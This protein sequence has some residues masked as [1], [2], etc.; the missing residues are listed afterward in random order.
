MCIAIIKPRGIEIPDRELLRKCWEIN[1]DGGGFM[2][3][4]G[5]KVTIHKGFMKFKKFYKFFK[6][7]SDLNDFK[8]KD[9]VIHFR[10]S[11]SGGINREC[12]HPFPVSNNLEELRY[13]NCTCPVGFAHNGIISG[14]G[15]KE[16][17]DTM[18]YIINVV[19]NIRD[20]ENSEALIDALAT[21]NSSRFVALTKDK[22]LKGG[23]WIEDNGL[24][25]SNS[26]YK[27]N[28]L[29]KTYVS[30]YDAWDD[31]DELHNTNSKLY[32]G[33]CACCGIALPWEELH[34]DTG[35][36]SYVCEDCKKE[37]DELDREYEEEQFK[38]YT[39]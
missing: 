6:H 5:T 38:L 15:T 12:T 3:N 24:F 11:T 33:E 14:Y 19:S 16:Y 4:D 7:E 9:V 22:I 35:Y 39:K 36:R 29:L 26:T 18:H 34:W 2:Y 21:E 10:I 1:P 25:F 20:L 23:T 37:L 31:W 30:K 28:R 17:S 27:G 8:N 32:Y 13:L